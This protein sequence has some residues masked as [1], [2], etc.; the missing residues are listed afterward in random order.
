MY[1]T[2]VQDELAD[3]TGG[4]LQTDLSFAGPSCDGEL[5]SCHDTSH[6]RLPADVGHAC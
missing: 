1:L 5:R 4:L 6:C 2:V 3:E